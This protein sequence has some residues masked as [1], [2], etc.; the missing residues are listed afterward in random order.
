[1]QRQLNRGPEFVRLIGLEHIPGR[2]RDLR[3][4]QR[5]V[6]GIGRE[7]D[8]RHILFSL[9]LE[10]GFHSVH[11]P[12]Q[13]N[14]HQNQV[15]MHVDR[16]ADRL[17]AGGRR[18]RHAIPQPLQAQLNVLRHNGFIFHDQDAGWFHGVHTLSEYC[19]C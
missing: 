2:R 6:V 18:S 3:A 15:R 17:F 16:L 11:F 7:V 10:G 8:D 9:N 14:I 1:M 19:S 13:Y 4:L 5:V 12:L